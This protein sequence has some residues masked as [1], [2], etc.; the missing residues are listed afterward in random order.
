[1][2]RLQ[3]SMA[4]AHKQEETLRESRYFTALEHYKHP[5]RGRKPLSVLKV[6]PPRK[7]DLRRRAAAGAD[8]TARFLK[9]TF[10][11]SCRS[12]LNEFVSLN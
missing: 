5:E 7:R 11:R 9:R 12:L 10:T 8:A 3:V 6:D 4:K 2:D 1:M